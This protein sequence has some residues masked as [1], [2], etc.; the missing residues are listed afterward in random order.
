MRQ[1][2]AEETSSKTKLL[3]DSLCGDSM[4]DTSDIDRLWSEPEKK[5][6]AIKVGEFVGKATNNDRLAT[7]RI[8]ILP[9]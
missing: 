1:T 5:L 4:S 8:T 6:A 2:R 7:K 3:P 9:P